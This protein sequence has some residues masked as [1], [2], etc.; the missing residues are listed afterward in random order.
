MRHPWVTLE[1]TDPLPRTVYM[2]INVSDQEQ[3]GAVL[4]ALPEPSVAR[5]LASISSDARSQSDST[6][7][8]VRRGAGDTFF[9]DR[10]PSASPARSAAQQRREAEAEAA[11]RCL[12][13]ACSGPPAL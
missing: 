7:Q 3:Q 8:S 5:R 9:S 4:H 1:G 13:A 2:R 11:V 12:S 6:S 10:S